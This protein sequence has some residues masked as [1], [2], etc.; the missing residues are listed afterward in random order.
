MR[1]IPVDPQRPDPDAIAE[2][3]GAI[4]EGNLVAFPTETVYGLG[5]NAL[6][7]LAVER[8]FEAKGRPSTNPIIV[9]AHDIASAK[10]LVSQWPDSADALAAAF[11]PGPLTLVLPKAARIPDVVTAGL[12]TVAV[13]VPAHPVA[14]ALLEAAGLPIAAP[15]ANRFTEISPTTAQH[16]RQSLGDAAG[17]ILDAGPTDVGIESTVLGLWGPTAVLLR[18]GTL[19]IER[20]ESIVGTIR[21]SFAEGGVNEPQRSPGLGERH[22]A[23]KA[24]VVL[25]KPAERPVILNEV[26]RLLRAG[27]PVGALVAATAPLPGVA[28]RPM[29]ADPLGYARVLYAELH[30]LDAAGCEVIFIEQV[31][32][33][34]DWDGVRDRLRRAA[35]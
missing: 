32:E 31:P 15:S 28:S 35:H 6:S 8:I 19:S 21:R 33:G 1:I 10:S 34:S 29:P 25:F 24:R 17:L 3:A 27:R 14:L 22:Y 23:P 26:S 9:H 16:V 7:T 12:S 11:W 5:A 4:R 20:L 30:A 2:A 18:P 13:R